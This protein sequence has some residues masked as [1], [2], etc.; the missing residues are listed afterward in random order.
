MYPVTGSMV[1][2]SIPATDPAKVTR[3]DVGAFS[4]VPTGAPKSSP[5]C[6]AYSPMGLKPAVIGPSTGAMRQTAA[7]AI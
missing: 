2:E 7:S 5:Q 6:P 1:T 4:G 3:P